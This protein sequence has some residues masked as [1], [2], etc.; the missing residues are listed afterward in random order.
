MAK[1]LEIFVGRQARY[2]VR[3]VSENTESAK[4]KWTVLLV[5]SSERMIDMRRTLL[6]QLGDAEEEKS[7]LHQKTDLSNAYC[8]VFT[9]L[10]KEREIKNKAEIFPPERIYRD[11]SLSKERTAE[12]W[13]EYVTQFTRK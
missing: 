5:E 8:S 6:N 9:F 12:E 13:E 3:K 4:Y 7:L 1:K 2:C 10:S 11:G